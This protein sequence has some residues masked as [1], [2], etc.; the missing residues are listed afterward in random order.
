MIYTEMSEQFMQKPLK[1]IPSFAN[2]SE[3][4]AF[5]ISLIAPIMLTGVKR[6]KHAC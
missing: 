4:K 3:E 2:E 1:T 6:K 5:W